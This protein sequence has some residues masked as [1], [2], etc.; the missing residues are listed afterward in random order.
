MSSLDRF[1][2]KLYDFDI[3]R[4]LELH[5]LDETLKGEF[6]LDSPFSLCPEHSEVDVANQLIMPYFYALL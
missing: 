2:S 1:F 5:I 6:A 3:S 4:L